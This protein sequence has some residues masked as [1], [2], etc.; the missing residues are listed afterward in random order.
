MSA[1]WSR[2]VPKTLIEWLVVAA[3]AAVLIA[4]LVPPVQW[5]DGSIKV[6]VKVVVFNPETGQPVQDARVAIVRG[7]PASEEFS[8]ADHRERLSGLRELLV[9]GDLGTLNGSVGAGTG[10][11]GTVTLDVEF[12]TGASHRNPV[13]RAH[14]RWYWVLVSAD[15]CG[16][17]AV[18]L[19]YESLTTKQL[20]EQQ[21]L[22]AYV[23]LLPRTEPAGGE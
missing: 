6:P 20:R 21:T 8:L 4:L 12:R 10:R 18:P 19:R 17:V 3:I 9:A 5:A 15:R 13:P 23:G 22:S 16:T 7:L 11:D 2:I 14:T 1:V